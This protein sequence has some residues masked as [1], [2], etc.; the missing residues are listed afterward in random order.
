MPV[1]L[2]LNI[3]PFAIEGMRFIPELAA[4]CGQSEVA[5]ELRLSRW[6]VSKGNPSVP[7]LL[8]VVEALQDKSD[9]FKA[10][11]TAL[12]GCGL[13]TRAPGA[14]LQATPPQAPS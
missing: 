14:R 1:A 11:N 6:F 9:Y 7:L 5:V 4:Y 8:E 10:I 2:N 12:L 13:C 3:K